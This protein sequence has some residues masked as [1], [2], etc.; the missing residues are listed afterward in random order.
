MGTVIG[1]WIDVSQEIGCVVVT[2]LR[3]RLPFLW[4]NHSLF[5]CTAKLVNTSFSHSLF[6]DEA[7]LAGG[8]GDWN[9]WR[10]SFYFQSPI[11]L[12][13]VSQR[14]FFPSS[15]LSTVGVDLRGDSRSFPISHWSSKLPIYRSTTIG[16][17]LSIIVMNKP[18]PP[19]KN[20][21]MPETKSGRS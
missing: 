7:E 12:F 20:I 6:S 14:S 13:N 3:L 17:R 15:S 11:R 16:R 19:W 5:L 4:F 9:T 21:R 8:G 10:L 2:Q 18:C 1:R